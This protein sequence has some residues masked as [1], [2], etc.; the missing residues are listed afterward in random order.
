MEQGELCVIGSGVALGY[1]NAPE[2]SD[3]AFVSNPLQPNVPQRMY[4][5]GDLACRTEEGLILFQ[6]RRDNQIKLRGNRIE[7]GEIE[8]A[9]MCI[10]GVENVCAVLDQP[11][12]QIVLFVETQR[13][14]TL[15]RFNLELKK[16]I[17]QYMMPGRLCC[18][19][20]LPHTPNDKI[21]R[22]ALKRL[23]SEE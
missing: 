7:L 8:N 10:E 11:N 2:L 17:P 9:A 18:M 14:F 20:K 1:W 12:Q 22:V 16:Y 15:R 6:G 21:D 3:K 5:T 19:E 13:E 23:L 4:R